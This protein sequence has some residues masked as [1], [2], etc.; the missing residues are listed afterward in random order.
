MTE[1]EPPKTLSDLDARISQARNSELK[2]N[3]KA[4]DSSGSQQSGI[5]QALRIGLEMV[6][7]VIVGFI[8]GWLL[9]NWLGTNP[10]LKIVFIL[11]GAAAGMLNVYRLAS[12][13]GYAVGYKESDQDKDNKGKE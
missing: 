3:A 10:W 9:D 8:I 5:G 4:G 1:H 13:F 11:L 7:A 12:G 6:S 2:R